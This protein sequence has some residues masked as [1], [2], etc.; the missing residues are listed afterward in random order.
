MAAVVDLDVAAWRAS[1]PRHAAATDE[2]IALWWETAIGI[3]DNGPRSPIPYDPPA[4]LTR[5]TILHALVCHLA[6][7]DQRGDGAVGRVAS[8]AEGSVNTSFD[9]G[10]Q[11]A[12]AAWWNQ[13]QCG[14]TAWLLLKPW[15]TGGLYFGGGCGH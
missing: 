10:A 5:R 8:A 4:V 7:L 12:R 13:T 15:R 2:Q 14:A 11:S 6:A 9:Y 1:F 3:V